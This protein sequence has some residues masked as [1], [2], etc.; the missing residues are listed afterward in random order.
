M[1]LPPFE[2]YL[3]RLGLRKTGGFHFHP[4]GVLHALLKASLGASEI[5][6]GVY[7][8]ACEA[9][10]TRFEPGSPYHLG[11]TLVGDSRRLIFSI[12]EGLRVTGEQ[13]P[14]P[15]SPLPALGGN[16]AVEGF[17]KLAAPDLD[18]ELATLRDA[19]SVSLRL[20]SP[21]RLERPEPLRE[22]GRTLLDAGCFPA[23]HFMDRLAARLRFLGAEGLPDVTPPEAAAELEGPFWL[24]VP[25]PGGPRRA[26][27][28]PK[29]LTFGGL[30]GTIRL[31]RLPAE[32][33]RIVVAGQYLHVGE[34]TRY[35]FGAYCLA[36]LPQATPFRPA[37][38][39][40]ERAAAKEAL[41]LALDETAEKSDASGVDGVSP[42]DF[43]FARSELLPALG[44]QLAS[45][46]YR[47]QPLL[48][49]LS[50]KPGGRVRALAIPTV[51]DRV[52]QRS[53]E[54][55]LGP[56]IDALLEDCSYAYRKGFS[57]QGAARAIQKA[58]DE[59]YRWVL[60]ADIESFFDAVSWNLLHGK[61]QALFPS[62]PVVRTLMEWVCSP[63]VFD[64]RTIQRTRGLPQGSPVAP[65][66]ANLFLDEFD[67]ELLG[68]DFRLVRYADDFVV[69][70]R[71][72]EGARAAQEAARKALAH[73][74]LALNDEKTGIRPMDAGFEYLGYIFCR[75][76]VVEPRAGEPAG[77]GRPI[78]LAPDA[79]PAA[80][81]LAQVPFARVRELAPGPR[82]GKPKSLPPLV[83]LSAGEQAPAPP[84]R[85]PV[86][87]LDPFTSLHVQGETLVAVPEEGPRRE[88]PLR[89][90]SHLVLAGRTRTTVPLLQALA[91][92][93]VPTFFCR[94]DGTLTSVF[95]PHEA[96]WA[97]WAAQAAFATDPGARTAFA[98]EVVAAKLHNGARLAVARGLPR[99]AAAKMREL[100]A[101]CA[102]KVTTEALRGLEGAG[103]AAFFGA[104]GKALPTGW[105][106]E[107]RR[108][109]PSTDPVNALL[110]FGYTMLHNHVSTALQA[111]G[112]NPRVGL[113]HEETGALH[114]LACDLQ[115]EFRFLVDGLVLAVVNRR[116][117]SPDDF[118]TVEDGG[119]CFLKDEPRKAFVRRFDERLLDSA[120][121][122]DTPPRTYAA[123]LD[124]QSRQVKDLVHRRSTLYCPFRVHG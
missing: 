13:T 9:G 85:K 96:D 81:W 99:E 21:L 64:N 123:H 67:E 111:A 65:L 56:S 46:A 27:D 121:G 62:D 52:A 2:R 24:D 83:P 28:R 94:R 82:K 76:V 57:R 53:V 19:E 41:E 20:L 112:L 40:R 68:Q 4:G 60:D 29:G 114:A 11:L 8:F 91:S 124:A 48:G 115:E 100:E 36:D 118:T 122:E 120:A 61:L 87:L 39:I 92:R 75:S 45:G 84:E 26:A 105:R 16:F 30:L 116:E 103:A 110:S 93:G 5:P 89:G 12:L 18:S 22:K 102:N 43:G 47:P 74:G 32:W 69:L 42:Q 73:I 63:V 66:L 117:V 33:L 34:K 1:K 70:C 71:D 55:L 49:L 109:H 6:D 119:A 15:D 98:R 72:L 108:K 25:V 104:L 14:D 54:A 10:Q 35:G 79:V 90:V 59:G 97:T 106:F 58:W 3:I 38:T 78:E 44:A 7:P 31:S 77:G 88:V 51:R 23:A 80:S 113:Y 101:E 86:Y 17:E 107:G 37:R 50:S 95:G